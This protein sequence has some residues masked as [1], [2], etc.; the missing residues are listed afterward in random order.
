MRRHP[1]TGMGD[2]GRIATDSTGL[3]VDRHR[4]GA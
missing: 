2:T 4:E 1:D 3:A